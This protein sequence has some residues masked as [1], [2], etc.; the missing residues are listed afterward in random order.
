MEIGEN[1]IA[2]EATRAAKESVALL[3]EM[4]KLIEG[5]PV[6]VVL[7]AT[8]IVA[9]NVLVDTAV[10]LEEGVSWYVDFFVDAIDRIEEMDDGETVQ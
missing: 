9:A 10:D 6:G 8:A 1:P 3:T 5:K 2:V 4:H 7:F